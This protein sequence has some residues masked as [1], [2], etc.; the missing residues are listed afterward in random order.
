MKD[1]RVDILSLFKDKLLV[2]SSYLSQLII[3]SRE[4]HHRLTIA[5][6]DNDKLRDA[7][8]TPQGNIVYTTYSNKV[9]VISESGKINSTHTHMKVPWHLSVSN[10]DVIYLVDLASYYGGVYQSTNEGVSWS[11]VFKSLY[12]WNCEQLIK[13]ATKSSDVFWTWES[14]GINKHLHVYNVYGR[15][16]D[17][18][19]TWRDIFPTTDG[20]HI[21]LSH[22]S[23]SYDGN[24]N[25][26]LSDQNNQAIHVLSVNGQ[27]RYQLLSSH[28]IK[29]KPW[30]L[31]VDKE[32]QLL[33]I[34]QTGRV[35]GVFKLIYGEGSN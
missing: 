16:F 20:K 23:L 30:R 34:G 33:Y 11:L 18:N 3:C 14:N 2:S 35:V 8:W 12:G 22:S 31:A 7:T 4:G 9:V 5:T 1:W 29:N 25:I 10:D 26:F 21:D 24:M 27:Y 32:R 6:N 19:M 28:Q 15:S 17:G 13:V